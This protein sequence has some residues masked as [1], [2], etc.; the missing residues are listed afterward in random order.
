[1]DS[2]VATVR[3]ALDPDTQSTFDRRVAEQADRLRAELDGGAFDSSGFAVGLE[4]ELYAVDETDALT[5]I[6]ETIFADETYAREIG[7]RR[8]PGAA[9]RAPPTGDPRWDVDDPAS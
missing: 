3:R 5:R 9:V 8:P 2:V 7:S 6:D 4:L 1:M